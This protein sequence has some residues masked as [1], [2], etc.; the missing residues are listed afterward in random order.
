VRQDEFDEKVLKILER[1]V[2]TPQRVEKALK[3]AFALA[4]ERM[5]K[6]PALKKKLQAEIKRLEAEKENLVLLSAQRLDD[7]A[8]VAKAINDRV[9]RIKTLETELSSLPDEFDAKKLAA[10]KGRMVEELT[11]FREMM[12]DRRNAPLA[13][14]VLRRLLVEPIRC[15]PIKRDGKPDSSIRGKATTGAFTSAPKLKIA[16]NSWRP[17]GKPPQNPPSEW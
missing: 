15:L 14:Q 16:A 2:L 17:H 11:R 12:A 10:L 6:D 13:R 7:P 4:K 3:E 8:G 1:D 9:Q 5:K